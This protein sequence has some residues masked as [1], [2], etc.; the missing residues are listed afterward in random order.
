M[1]EETTSQK[2][3]ATFKQKLEGA[4]ESFSWLP[5]WS[6]E[7]EWHRAV[8]PVLRNEIRFGSELEPQV[9]D[10][11]KELKAT[12]DVAPAIRTINQW[13]QKN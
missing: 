10:L 9:Q 12:S 7:H 2:L 1:A 6:W 13:L 8:L 3:T 11:F 5:T 4:I